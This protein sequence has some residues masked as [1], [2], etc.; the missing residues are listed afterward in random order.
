MYHNYLEYNTLLK[1]FIVYGPPAAGKG[2]ICKEFPEKNVIAVG[3]LL[4]KSGLVKDG[5][6]VPVHITNQLVYQE[7]KKRQDL[8]YVILDGYPRNQA[9]IDFIK[10][11]DFISL[12]KLINLNCSDKSVLERASVREICDCGASFHPQLKPSTVEGEC[13]LCHSPLTRRVD[14]DVLKIR[15]RLEIYHNETPFV[16][17]AFKDIRVDIDVDDHTQ[18][19]QGVISAINEIDPE[20]LRRSIMKQNF[21]DPRLISVAC[22]SKV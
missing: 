10:N 17:L 18:F 4:R 2:S 11:Q 6:M 16:L 19:Y 7:L 15:R 5:E 9:Q 14:D 20:L 13:D 22:K 8:D 1:I 12:E 3:T 21:K